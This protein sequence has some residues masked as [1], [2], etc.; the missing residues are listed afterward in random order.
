MR[1][2]RVHVTLATLSEGDHS[3]PLDEEEKN[4]SYRVKAH[5]IKV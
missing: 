2:S 4:G 1:T 5:F 3:D